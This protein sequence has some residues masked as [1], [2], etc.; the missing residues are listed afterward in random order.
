MIFWLAIKIK[1]LIYE[2]F[3][4]GNRKSLNSFTDKMMLVVRY[5]QI[6]CIVLLCM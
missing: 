4:N 1:A 3:N 2:I 6:P 5:T